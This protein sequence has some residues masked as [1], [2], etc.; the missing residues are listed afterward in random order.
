MKVGKINKTNVIKCT[1]NPYWN[2]V[3]KSVLLKVGDCLQFLIYD[4]DFM[5]TDD[6]MG[7]CKMTQIIYSI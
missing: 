6:Y 1:L 4:W 2:F 7:T 5:A 3:F